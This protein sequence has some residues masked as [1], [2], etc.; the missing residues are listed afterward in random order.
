MSIVKPFAALRPNKEYV[1]KVISPPYDVLSR[2]EA[3]KLAS[4]NPFSFLHICRAEI[5]LPH[6]DDP[7]HPE[8]YLKASSNLNAFEMQNIMIRD[9]SPCLYIYRQSM[10]GRIQTGIVGCVSIDEYMENRIKKHELTRVEK[11]L[12]RIN[13]FDACNANTE[14]IFLTYRHNSSVN[15]L[16]HAWTI[17]KNPVYDFTA[18][19]GVG[20]SLWVINCNETIDA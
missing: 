9:N 6:I 5:D 3:A 4:A 12:D 2:E 16:I 11:E 13:H 19:D 1:E 20:H 8:V 10:E 7:Y 18:G 15:D 17:K 14:P